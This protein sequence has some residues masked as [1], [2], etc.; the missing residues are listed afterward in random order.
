MFKACCC[1]YSPVY[2]VP[3]VNEP[4][5]HLT[6]SK[7]ISCDLTEWTTEHYMSKSA[8]QCETV[9]N[10]VKRLQLN[11]QDKYYFSVS[12]SIKLKHPSNNKPFNK[13]H[14]IV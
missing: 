2:R 6:H 13:I 12:L 5:F 4:D 11:R 7:R 3:S 8:R 1:N 14:C 9:N 10:I